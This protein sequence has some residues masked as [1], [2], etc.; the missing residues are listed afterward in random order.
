MGRAIRRGVEKW[1]AC[2]VIA[3]M[4]VPKRAEIT[5]G[6]DITES[7][8]SI[9]GFALTNSPVTT[10]DLGSRFDKTVAGIDSAGDSSLTMWDEVITGAESSDPAR[11]VL[12]KDTALFFVRMPYGNVAGKRCEVWAVTSTGVNDQVDLSAAGQ[13]VVGFSITEVPEQNAIVPALT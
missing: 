12:A 11:D 4:A 6:V 13:Y 10:P 1:Y 2:P 8:A 7:I 9:S 5:A 3:D